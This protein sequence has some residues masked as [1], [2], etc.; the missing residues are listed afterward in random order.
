MRRLL[1]F[2]A[3]IILFAG[4][5]AA[6]DFSA[7]TVMTH[8]G[9]KTTGKIFFSTDRFRM[10]MT[11]PQ[12]MSTITRTDKKVVWNIMHKE[13][14]YMEMPFDPKG[15]PAVTEKMEGE[16]ERKQVGAETVD[17]HA[18]KKFLITYK[19]DNKKNEIYQWLA[20]DINFPVKSAAVDGSWIQ[21][22]RNIRMGAQP[23]SLFEVPSGY[24]KMQ[25]PG[26]M[27][28]KR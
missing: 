6:L 14:M 28:F 19:I 5:A 2:L 21:E 1:I 12:K 24:K 22:Y 16:V 4:K 23:E 13:K 15:R 26:G 20:T 18:A 3:F 11:S 8:G 25:M 10:D 7:E 27:N 17:G 9:N